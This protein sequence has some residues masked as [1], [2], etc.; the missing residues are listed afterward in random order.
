MRCEPPAPDH[1][2]V[3]HLVRGLLD[4]GAP[5]DPG[6]D[7][8]KAIEIQ[9]AS[10]VDGAGGGSRNI[11]GEN[12]SRGGEG[13]VGDADGRP[14]GRPEGVELRRRPQRAGEGGKLE[15]A[16]RGAVRVGVEAHFGGVRLAIRH[17]AMRDKAVG[18]LVP[19]VGGEPP[20]D[21]VGVGIGLEV[22][23][24]QLSHPRPNRRRLVVVRR[25]MQG[26]VFVGGKQPVVTGGIAEIAVDQHLGGMVEVPDRERLR[27]EGTGEV[28][29]PRAPRGEFF[30]DGPADGGVGVGGE[31]G[32]GEGGRNGGLV[33]KRGAEPRGVRPRDRIEPFSRTGVVERLAQVVGGGEP[34]QHGVGVGMLGVESV[35][36][37]LATAGGG[38]VGPLVEV[39]VARCCG[40][41]GAQDVVDPPTGAG[42]AGPVGGLTVLSAGEPLGPSGG[43]LA[44]ATGDDIAELVGIVPRR[45]TQAG[46]TPEQE[47]RFQV[48]QL[49]AARQPRRQGLEQK[50]L[51]L[52]ELAG[53]DRLGCGGERPE[54]IDLA[55]RVAE[56]RA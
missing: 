52:I 10:L 15:D 20:P 13:A 48:R 27:G 54:W 55:G 2:R 50:A 35:E 42:E 53:A 31:A 9:P 29:T 12:G 49:H 11:R 16:P 39:V 14:Q 44:P 26:E 21:L 19:A 3:G 7:G 18:G 4:E 45:D 8:G 23:R 24:G 34:N 1:G 6:E 33:G 46:P 22:G 36:G 25:G 40:V 41:V 28:C 37:R 43:C 51:V 38:D 17:G 5:A 30:V 47:E 32:D 56:V